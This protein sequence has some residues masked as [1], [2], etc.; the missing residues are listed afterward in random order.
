[1]P[2]SWLPLPT[3]CT[4]APYDSFSFGM[5]PF[6]CSL[7]IP[8]RNAA[9]FL[10][11]LFAGVQAQRLPFAEIILWDDASTD[12]SAVIA[13]RHGARILRAEKSAGPATARN[14]LVR[15]ARCDWVHLHDADDLISPDYL[16]TL[17]SQA[18]P[19]T[20]LVVCDADWIDSTSRATVIAWR[21]HAAEYR[22]APAAYLLTHPLGINNC[23]YRRATF[24]AERGY[25]PALV[26][27]EDTDF[28]IR[29]ALAGRRFVFVPQ[30]LTWSVRHP[31]GISMDYTRNWESRLRCLQRYATA[32]PRWLNPVLADEAEKAAAALAALSSPATT[33]A[34]ALCRQLGGDP[35][36]TRHPVLR[37]LKPFLPT[38]TLLRWQERRRTGRNL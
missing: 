34:I 8:C 29:L 36:S 15:A 2:I 4:H 26:P 9:R 37:L 11:A 35:P 32:M 31:G 27:W 6:L 20:D 28:H 16:A 33:S 7:L 10:P 25:D 24:L 17:A 5:T 22:A 21:Y 12:D 13:E 18:T 14:E 19:E 3:P 38:A 23:I 1:M 30:V